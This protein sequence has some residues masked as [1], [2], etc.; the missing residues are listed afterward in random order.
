MVDLADELVDQLKEIAKRKGTDVEALLR[1]HVIQEWIGKRHIV[2][3]KIFE[4][5][6]VHLRPKRSRHNLE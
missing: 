4:E 2:N 1:E 3:E 5:T 6:S